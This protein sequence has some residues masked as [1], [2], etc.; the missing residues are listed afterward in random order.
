[1]K[2]LPAFAVFAAFSVPCWSQPDPKPLAVCASTPDLASIAREVGGDTVRVTTFV[3]GPEDPHFVEARP[4][5]VKALAEAD[6]WIHVGLELEVGWAPVLLLQSRNPRVQVGAPGHLDASTA[7]TPLGIRKGKLDRSM[8]D[9]HGSGNPHYLLDPRN[10]WLVAC[11]VRDVLVD[12]RPEQKA[13]I[14]ARCRAFG[15]R[16]GEAMVGKKL[17]DKY[18]WEKL[19]LLAEHGK[20]AEFLRAQGDGAVEGWLGMLAPFRGAAVVVDHDM[21]PYFTLCFGLET[22]ATLEPIPGVPPTTKHLSLVV[23]KAKS[24]KVRAILASPYYDPRHAA[25]VARECGAKVAAMAH[26]TGGR[27]GTDDYLTMLES[28]V[29]KLVEALAESR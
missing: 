3:K 29:K 17:S 2:T 7:I 1:M 23:A 19:T 21:W 16:L 4:S 9:V 18:E 10:G 11:K 24:S 6:L 25:F 26:Q 5:F 20:L 22:V 28:N 27:P 8:G 14:G 15:A 13:A 12:L